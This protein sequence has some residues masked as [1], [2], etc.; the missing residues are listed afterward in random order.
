MKNKLEKDFIIDFF[1][2]NIP[3]PPYHPYDF[4]KLKLG[5]HKHSL[6]D[7]LFLI[8]LLNM[9]DYFIL[10]FCNNMSYGKS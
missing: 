7:I 3:L 5:V 1:Y 4:Q 6:Q 10:V 8:N 2:L 9:Q